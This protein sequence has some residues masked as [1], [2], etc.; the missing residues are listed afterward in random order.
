MKISKSKLRQIIKEELRIVSESIEVNTYKDLEK[1][2]KAAYEQGR[3][4]YRPDQIVAGSEGKPDRRVDPDPHV[5]VTNTLVELIKGIINPDGS[6]EKPGVG[7]VTTD[8][9]ISTA[10][11]IKAGGGGLRL[12]VKQAIEDLWNNPGGIGVDEKQKELLDT[13]FPGYDVDALE[14]L[15]HEVTGISLRMGDEWHDEY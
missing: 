5:E 2:V 8:D 12:D 6:G 13:Q 14:R 10:N 3:K 7:K 4:S 9:I 11:K 1:A 15:Y